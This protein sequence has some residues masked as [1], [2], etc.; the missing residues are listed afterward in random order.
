MYLDFDFA[1]SV[2]DEKK[3]HWLVASV[4]FGVMDVNSGYPKML[5][6]KTPAL[7]V[8]KENRFEHKMVEWM[9]K[10]I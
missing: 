8:Y 10:E 1:V 5:I 4:Y 6:L 9:T 3:H 2:F 7:R